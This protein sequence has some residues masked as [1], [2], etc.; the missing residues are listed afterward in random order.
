VTVG[1]AA[2]VLYRK[3][4]PLLLMAVPF[5]LEHKYQDPVVLFVSFCVQNVV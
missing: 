2:D 5:P 1:N 4:V 3:W